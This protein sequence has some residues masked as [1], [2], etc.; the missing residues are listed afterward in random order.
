MTTQGSFVWGILNWVITGYLWPKLLNNLKNRVQALQNGCPASTFFFLLLICL[1]S[2]NYIESTSYLTYRYI[3]TK[4]WTSVKATMI[5]FKMPPIGNFSDFGADVRAQKY[6]YFF[7]PFNILHNGF[8]WPKM[9]NK[10]R[11]HVH[12]IP[13]DCLM[14]IFFHERVDT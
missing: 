14:A 13:N 10:L 3:N 12:A 2:C 4:G 6:V 9:L 5:K 11:I 7:N 1:Q 8:L